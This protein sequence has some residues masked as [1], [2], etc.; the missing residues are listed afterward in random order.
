M[1]SEANSDTLARMVKSNPEFETMIATVIA[2][3]K[4]TTS[5]FVHELRN[6]LSLLKGTIQYIELKHPEAKEYKYWDQMQDLI[7]DMD[8]IM[9]DAS[10]LNTCNYIHKEDT[11]LITLLNNI[12]RSF[13]PQ[14]YSQQIELSLTLDPA[15]EEYFTNYCCDAIKLKQSFSNLIKNAFEATVPGNFVH[16]NLAYLPEID[17]TPSKLSIQISNNGQ[18]IPEEVIE[19]I[20]VPF[21]TYKKGGT[22]VGLALVKKV[23][24]LHYGSVSVDSSENLTTFTILLPV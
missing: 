1:F 11:N 6:P 16:I 5:M 3:N 20:F 19:N 13:M 17:P 9:A 4:R 2:D 21:V 7:N 22:G 23:I 18:L 12:I 24:D 15:C 10:L 8:H 14:A